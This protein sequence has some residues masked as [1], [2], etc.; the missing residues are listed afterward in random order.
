MIKF[1]RNIPLDP[2]DCEPPP[3]GEFLVLSVRHSFSA[4]FVYTKTKS[5]IFHDY[6]SMSPR[7][8]CLS[9]AGL[10]CLPFPLAEVSDQ[11]KREHDSRRLGDRPEAASRWPLV[12]DVGGS[13]EQGPG[14]EK[15]DPPITRHGNPPQ[16]GDKDQKKTCYR[17]D[18]PCPQ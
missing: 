9:L 13:G 1:M 4:N 14:D 12:G 6:L 17:R 11:D 10:S 3:Y 15:A 2:A 7:R 5:K 16:P 18:R 8:Q